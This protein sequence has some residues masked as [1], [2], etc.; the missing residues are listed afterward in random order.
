MFL[1]ALLVDVVD[2]A[3]KLSINVEV[4]PSCSPTFECQPSEESSRYRAFYNLDSIK[5]VGYIIWGN[6]IT[7]LPLCVS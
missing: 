1:L 2:D 3:I 7:T 6:F 5:H 4:L